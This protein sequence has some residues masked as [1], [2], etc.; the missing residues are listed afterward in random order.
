MQCPLVYKNL[1]GKYYCKTFISGTVDLLQLSPYFNSQ[2][3]IYSR[4]DY[5]IPS[6]NNSQT[7]RISNLPYL[8]PR[9]R[10]ST[11]GNYY[12]YHRFPHYNTRI[13]V[14]YFW[15]TYQCK[16]KFIMSLCPFIFLPTEAVHG[17]NSG[18][19]ITERLYIAS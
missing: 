15:M 8:I 6:N 10:L 2:I 19:S 11:Q 4:A 3:D 7:P 16:M 18:W 14:S 9:P 12:G 1:M 17:Q 13:L 5:H